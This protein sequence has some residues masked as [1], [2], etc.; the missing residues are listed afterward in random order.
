MRTHYGGIATPVY[1][2]KITSK[3]LGPFSKANKDQIRASQPVPQKVFYFH[4]NDT[5]GTC[6]IFFHS[7]KIPQKNI[8]KNIWTVCTLYVHLYH[9]R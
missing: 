7:D 6:N 8:F 3:L 4:P 9:E 2:P 5:V 1:P